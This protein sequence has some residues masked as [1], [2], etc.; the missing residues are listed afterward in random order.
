MTALLWFCIAMC[1]GM[2]CLFGACSSALRTFNHL[3]LE[4]ELARRGRSH[5]LAATLDRLPR[6]TLST[7]TLRI[8]FNI[9]VILG[10]AHLLN[11]LA[12]NW[13][14]YLAT[15][16]LLVFVTIL[17]FSVAIPNAWAKY[18]GERLLAGMLP[19]LFVLNVLLSPITWLL[20]Q[21]DELV[22][23]LAGAP[24]AGEDV[25][26][27]EREI[28]SVVAEGEREG[29]VDA[30]EKQMIASV[31]Q[32]QDTRADQIMTPRTDIIAVDVTS[33]IATVLDTIH[34][35][36]HS[37]I[38]VYEGNLDN[39]IGLLYTK[40]LLWEI[41]G[42]QQVPSAK[43]QVPNEKDASAAGPQESESPRPGVPASP[44]PASRPPTPDP[45]PLDV[46]KVMRPPLFV[47]ESR[48]VGDL[49]D[50]LRRTKVHLAIVLDEFG[51]TAGLVTIEDILE[52]IVGDI[53]DEHE[54]PAPSLIRKIDD[55]T[56]EIGGRAHVD[57]VNSQLKLALPENED[58]DTIGGMV[59]AAMGRIPRTGERLVRDNVTITVAQ[60][61][62]RRIIRLRLELSPAPAPA[63][64]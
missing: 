28:M 20:H 6:L 44:R 50:D 53:A 37:R 30:E 61:E 54:A 60:A 18:A 27:A 29:R 34:R 24:R 40:D 55:R 19:V 35:A 47:P 45:R 51:G 58:Y 14:L 16:G 59:I 21:F 63:G 5:W 8:L 39:I 49:L 41:S 31:L 22:R 10:M 36:G 17:V 64:A 1:A 7:A 46:R 57:D 13:G 3:R 11:A 56:W 2:S 32:F 25:Q 23:R 42:A 4:E 52:E 62:P 15:T 26:Q 33:D 9:L 43:C 38:P 48:A 12:D